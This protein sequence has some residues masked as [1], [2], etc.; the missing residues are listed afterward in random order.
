MA[1]SD[2]SRQLVWISSLLGELGMKPDLPVL[3]GDNMGSLFWA[4]NPMT[5]KRS[6]HINI[7]YH[8]ICDVIKQEKIDLA[9]IKGSKNPADIL[10]KNLGQIL[11][12]RFVPSLGIE[13]SPRNFD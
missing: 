1:L 3:H 4:S 9:F 8:Y 5:E 10:T 7:R 2:C 6:K 13:F 12:R 11:F